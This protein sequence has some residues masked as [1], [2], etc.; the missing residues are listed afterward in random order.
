MALPA[1]PP[2]TSEMIRQQYGGALPFNIRDYFRGGARV[3]NTGVNSGIPTSGTISFANFLGQG[4]SGGGSSLVVSNSGA[5]G[6]QFR[7]E[8]APASLTVSANGTV[9][10]SGGSGA[11]TCTWLH[12]SGS[13]AIGTPGANNFSPSFSASVGK[14]TA[15]VAVKRCT[16][17]D[18]VNT[19]VSTD[20][21]VR[22]E[23]N[24]DL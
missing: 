22:L 20:M 18:G 17:S 9:F 14:N 1:S 23:Y 5:V 24:T 19:P 7:N 16:V 2:I 10:A 8:P 12:I 13:T 6:S 4:G 11:Y 3:P 21:N 15:I